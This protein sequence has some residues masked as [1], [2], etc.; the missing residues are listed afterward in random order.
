[1]LRI[2]YKTKCCYVI[3]LSGWGIRYRRYG[4]RADCPHHCNR[5]LNFSF[6]IS[7]AIWP[8][9]F[10]TTPSF[11]SIRLFPSLP[12]KYPEANLFSRGGT[13]GAFGSFTRRK[14]WLPH[15]P[16]RQQHWRYCCRFGIEKSRF[17][18]HSAAVFP[19]FFGRFWFCLR[20]SS[21]DIRWFSLA[22]FICSASETVSLN[23]FMT[24]MAAFAVLVT[25]IQWV[26][27]SLH[28]CVAWTVF[29]VAFHTTFGSS[30]TNS[31]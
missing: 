11:P 20:S 3:R 14:G 30:I 27:A 29:A 8:S 6:S 15:L 13:L 2:E 4:H 22:I 25:S 17:W 31:E 10:V 1:M 9:I 7:K 26:V 21:L 18:K 16:N 5:A 19:H 28:S 12:L 24:S 23:R